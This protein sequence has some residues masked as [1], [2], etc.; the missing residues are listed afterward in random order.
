MASRLKEW[1]QDLSKG[2]VASLIAGVILLL[3]VGS[4]VTVNIVNNNSNTTPPPSDGMKDDHTVNPGASSDTTT[5]SAV[6][7]DPRE[8]GNVDVA[9]RGSRYFFGRDFYVGVGDVRK[10]DAGD[11]RMASLTLQERNLP[12]CQFVNPAS[13]RF[14][15]R[16]S[17]REY[18]VTVD[19][20][21]VLAVGVNVVERTGTRTYSASCYGEGVTA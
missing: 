2:V 1:S 19:I 4:A 8:N 21:N 20:T 9:A 12:K 14:F 7:F 16:R 13:G 3:L 18:E 17:N 5:V 15:L 10:S 11:L 6:R